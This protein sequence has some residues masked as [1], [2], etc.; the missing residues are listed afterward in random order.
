LEKKATILSTW[1]K[2]FKNINYFVY[3]T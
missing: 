2:S 1:K 3:Y